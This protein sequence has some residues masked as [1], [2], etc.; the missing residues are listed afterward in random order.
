M[1]KIR[2][3]LVFMGMTLLQVAK[4]MRNAASRSSDLTSFWKIIAISAYLRIHSGK[5]SSKR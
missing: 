2:I 3:M 4:A 5:I 1:D